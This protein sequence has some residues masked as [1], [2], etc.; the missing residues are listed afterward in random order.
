MYES[1]YLHSKAVPLINRPNNL[2]YFKFFQLACRN[3][4]DIPR[5]L[6]TTFPQY[7][8][9]ELYE[10]EMSPAEACEAILLP[11]QPLILIPK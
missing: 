5:S 8:T 6:I 7:N 9:L 11:V 1:V 3:N 10:K 4:A 2:G